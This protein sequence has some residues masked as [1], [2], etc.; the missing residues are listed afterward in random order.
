ME[1]FAGYV[2]VVLIV[3]GF[4]T[5]LIK[6]FGNR[7]LY[8]SEFIFNKAIINLNNGEI[9]SIDVKEWINYRESTAIK[10]ISQDGKV[11]YTDLKNCVLIKE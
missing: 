10:I 1:E 7:S 2:I 11:Y 9:I 6:A 4:M 5:L 8:D 3:I